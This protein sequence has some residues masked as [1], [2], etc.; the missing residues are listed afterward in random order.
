MVWIYKAD[1]PVLTQSNDVPL[2]LGLEG[3]HGK[4]PSMSCSWVGYPYFSAVFL[5]EFLH[6]GQFPAMFHFT[7]AR[8]I[9]VMRGL[10]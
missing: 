8:N 9:P 6:S 4:T 10:S 1:D 7:D 5:R 3:Y 2:L